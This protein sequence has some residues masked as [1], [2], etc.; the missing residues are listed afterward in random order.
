MLIR[1]RSPVY[2]SLDWLKE[3][4]AITD[5]DIEVFERAKEYRNLLAHGLT[6]LLMEGL[7]QDFSERFQDM[8]TLLDKIERWWI[9]NVEIP[10]DPDFVA[11]AGEIDEE[12][13]IPGTMINLQMILDIALG[14][15]ERAYVYIREFKKRVQKG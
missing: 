12:G 3:A 11:E 15:D 14:P 1:N 7:P 9:V 2:A 10:T 8:V 4:G 5:A 6:R 13:I